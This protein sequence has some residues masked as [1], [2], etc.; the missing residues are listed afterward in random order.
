MPDASAGAVRAR[1]ATGVSF[2]GARPGVRDLAGLS[3]AASI[4]VGGIVLLGWWLGIDG[5]KS[6]VPGAL[7]MK[8]N[9]A[10]VF[11]LLGVGMFARTR[12][13]GMWRRH[14]A[15][16]PLI[17]AMLL[18]AAVGS[19]YLVGRDS[20]IDQWLFR[21]LPGQI[22]TLHP[23]R[24]S[25]MTVVCF[26]LIGTGVLLASRN[27]TSAA[28]PALLLGALIVALLNILD[29]IFEGATP[30][31]LAGYTQMALNTAVMMVVLSIGAMALLPDGGPLEVFAG[32]S[33]SAGLARRLVI[34]SLVAPVAL[35][36]LRL[37][38]EEWGLYGARYGA[39]LTVLGTFVF[40]TAVI[41]QSARSAR[42]TE[43]ARSAALEERDR[44]FDVSSDML[45]TASADGYFIRLNPAWQA[46]L[47][48]DL[49]E[50]RSRPF[51]EFVHPDDR[52]ATN[53]EAA[54]QVDE[55]KTVLN[56]ENRYR[57][58]DGSYRWLEWTSTPSADG[59]R[60]YAV[61][62]DVTGRKE[63]EERR[64]API[65]AVREQRAEARRKIEATIAQ[66]AFRPVFQPVVDLSSGSVVGF[67][68]L[69][70]F[71]D[72]CRPDV[73][74]ARALECGLGIELERV[75]LE[76]AVREARLLP[77]NAWLSLNVSPTLLSDVEALRPLLGEPS[78]AVVLEITEHES[79]GAYA[80]LREALT[81]LGSH[82]RLAVDD[83]GA[84]IANFSHLV[85]LRPDFVKIDAGLVRGVDT[86][87]SRSALVVGLVHFAEAAGCLIIAE[88]IET[89]GERA[90]V[91]E[92]GVRLG[93][94]Y[95]LAR[96]AA[97]ERWRATRDPG[98][99]RAS[100]SNSRRRLRI[101][102]VPR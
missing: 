40:L 17:A 55:G 89:E 22:G 32:Q 67:E 16:A 35:S 24:M 46:T 29:F 34:A 18:S 86:D 39:S 48:Y 95:L 20:G 98:E 52:A 21:E 27:R 87:V 57:H 9:T 31:L 100:A 73:V 42:R 36:W 85:E 71:D 70:R 5:L 37:Q 33:S 51:I 58:R 77:R 64:L 43:I 3:A 49:A 11:V 76:A 74:F 2:G 101:A 63:E 13:I 81:R 45:A 84:G 23:N 10:L 26:L 97:A 80:P 14:L 56:F 28:V 72:G 47:G 53:I 94:G 7:T 96:P 65:L 1:L 61:A 69:T 92:L 79:I 12:P 60:L 83:A 90:T 91:A 4:L 50:L 88:G 75:T 93:Q 66:R 78:R 102:T 30:S 41:W 38:G 99:R 62:R 19:Q 82:V 68:A 59:S 44:F 15:V 54:R 6:L 8:V 25:P